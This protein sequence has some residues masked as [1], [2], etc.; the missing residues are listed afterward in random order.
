MKNSN[1]THQSSHSNNSLC[2]PPEDI[3]SH[4]ISVE[5][6]KKYLGKFELTDEKIL[7]IRNYLIG[8]IDKSMS[9][10]LDDFR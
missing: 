3:N 1:K 6:C 5:D 2:I 10:Y 8:I 9:S 4:V 7:E